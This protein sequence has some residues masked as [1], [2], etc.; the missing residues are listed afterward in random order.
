MFLPVLLTARE[1]ITAL[2]ILVSTATFSAGAFFVALHNTTI[3]CAHDSATNATYGV[4]ILTDLLTFI[5]AAGATA[6][7]TFIGLT[8]PPLR[9]APIFRVD[10]VDVD[11][12]ENANWQRHGINKTIHNPRYC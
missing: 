8:T 9:S 4:D 6:G 1:P 12:H 11:W 2:T 10:G 7:A 5:A 3:D